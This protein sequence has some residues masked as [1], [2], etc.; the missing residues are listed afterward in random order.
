MAHGPKDKNSIAMVGSRQT[1]HYALRRRASWR[2][3]SLTS[4]SR[5]SA[6]GRAGLI[7]RRI[8]AHW[9]PKGRTICVPNAPPLCF[10]RTKELFDRIAENG[11]GIR[12]SRSIATAT[13]N[14]FAIRNRIVA[15]MTLGTVVVGL[16]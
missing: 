5:W 3:N 4:A 9:R 12:S 13:N 2:I 8:K 16:T 15:G 14:P 11:R 7:R 10:R 6:V 1:T